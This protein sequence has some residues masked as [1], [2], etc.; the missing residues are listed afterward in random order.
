MNTLSGVTCVMWFRLEVS[1]EFFA[2]AVTYVLNIRQNSH[3]IK[4][5][6]K[7]IIVKSYDNC[8]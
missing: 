8:P 4:L 5:K 6:K 1:N 2:S 3:H 7:I